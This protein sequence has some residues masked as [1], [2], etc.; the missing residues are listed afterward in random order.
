MQ[1]G[2]RTVDSELATTPAIAPFAART[3]PMQSRAIAGDG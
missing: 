1:A 3:A 2:S